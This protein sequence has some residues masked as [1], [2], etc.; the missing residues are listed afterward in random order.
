MEHC[1]QSPL[2]DMVI[3]LTWREEAPAILYEDHS[4]EMKMEEKEKE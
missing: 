1:N 3:G 4:F 2:M